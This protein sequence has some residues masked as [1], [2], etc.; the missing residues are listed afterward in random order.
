MIHN[1]YIQ[2]HPQ[3]LC[4][5]GVFRKIQTLNILNS[6]QKNPTRFFENLAG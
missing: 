6:A 4:F 5:E 1:K 2:K 3:N